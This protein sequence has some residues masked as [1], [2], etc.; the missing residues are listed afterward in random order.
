[1]ESR[2]DQTSGALRC[3]IG[4]PF[5]GC[6]LVGPA[7]SGDSTTSGQ[8]SRPP[9]P[10]GVLPMGLYSVKDVLSLLICEV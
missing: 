3:G 2:Q 6:G 4:K 7:R 5:P 1:M 8:T 10:E 9:I